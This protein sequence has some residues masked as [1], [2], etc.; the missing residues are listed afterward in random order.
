[1]PST[2]PR[3]IVRRAVM[4]VAVLVL[5]TCA[6]WLMLQEPPKSE[7]ELSRGIELGMY[8]HQIYGVMQAHPIRSMLPDGRELWSYGEAASDYPVRVRFTE[9]RVDR[10]ERGNEI[11]ESPQQ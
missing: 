10:I 3:R 8:P 4:V 1:M 6:S 2:R 11:D 5:L 9:G 7:L